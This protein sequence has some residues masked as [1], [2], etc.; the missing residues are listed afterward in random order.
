MTITQKQANEAIEGIFEKL[1]SQLNGA[2]GRYFHILLMYVLQL[3]GQIEDQ[4]ASVEK[5]P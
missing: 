2:L 3:E 4:A 5:T 1:E